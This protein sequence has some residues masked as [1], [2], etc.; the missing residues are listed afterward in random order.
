MSVC[1]DI[2]HW[3]TKHTK[4]LAVMGI[5]TDDA[6]SAASERMSS[7]GLM[8]ML[9]RLRLKVERLERNR[10]VEMQ[11]KF[12][13]AEQIAQLARRYVDGGLVSDREFKQAIEQFERQGRNSSG[14]IKRRTK[15]TV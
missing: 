11:R 3:I 5:A 8:R 9:R 4:R 1:I 12:Q 14:R 2:P 15:P 13:A 7:T 6:G 10:P